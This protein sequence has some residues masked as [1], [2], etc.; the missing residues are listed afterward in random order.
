VVNPVLNARIDWPWFIASQIAFGLAAGCFISRA[1][2]VTTMQT[3]PLA[4][5]AGVE[6]TGVE[7]DAGSK[8]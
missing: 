1:V 7:R 4:A 5:R 3:W 8:P 2:P 6:A